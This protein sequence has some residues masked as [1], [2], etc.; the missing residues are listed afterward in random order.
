MPRPV[1]PEW[2]TVE[3]EGYEVLIG[4]HAKANDRLTFR[5]ADPQ[6]VWLHAAGVPGSHVL[7]RNPEGGEVPQA[8]VRKAAEL[9]AF[10]SKARNAGG[11]VEVHVCR[12][13]D[14]RKPRGAKPGTVELR[15]WE[16][17][18]VYPRAAEP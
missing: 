11:K 12:A 7:I 8:V 6:D 2:S 13:C 4:A 16:G 17:M 5:E 14:V 1:P 18:K 10:H 3:I 15:R 9:A